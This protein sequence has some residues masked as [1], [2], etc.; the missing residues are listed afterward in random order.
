MNFDINK[1]NQVK[2]YIGKIIQI[3]NI[4]LTWNLFFSCINLFGED[5]K[6]LNVG[7]Q[8]WDITTAE[9]FHF[10]WFVCFFFRTH[11][12]VSRI[13]K[14]VRKLACVYFSSRRTSSS[15]DFFVHIVCQPFSRIRAFKLVGFE[16]FK[17]SRYFLIANLINFSY[18]E[19]LL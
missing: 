5:G 19:M 18:T 17:R 16:S 13:Q 8:G 14:I 15:C 1:S 6:Y 7:Y 9:D 3:W 2:K 10:G 11:C 4:L 12:G